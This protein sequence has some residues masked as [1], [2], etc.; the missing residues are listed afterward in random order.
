LRSASAN[1]PPISPVPMIVI[2]RIGM[3]KLGNRTTQRS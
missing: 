3:N 1:D 2:W